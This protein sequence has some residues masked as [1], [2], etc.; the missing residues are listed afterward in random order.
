MRSGI[1]R[2]STCYGGSWPRPK[3]RWVGVL[4]R[5]DDLQQRQPCSKEVQLVCECTLARC[6]P[7]KRL[8]HVLGR[9]LS[10]TWRASRSWKLA[11]L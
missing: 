7:E 6:Y 3:V 11:C 5:S 10:A 9:T 4:W 1:I 8:W 2:R